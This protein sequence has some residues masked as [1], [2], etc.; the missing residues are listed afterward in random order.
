[1][2]YVHPIENSPEVDHAVAPIGLDKV[3][4]KSFPLK[5]PI[6][7]IKLPHKNKATVKMIDFFNFVI[8][9]Q[10]PNDSSKIQIIFILFAYPIGQI[11]A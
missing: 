5:N 1:M 10:P 9:V 3:I 6:K 8:T 7:T 4:A 11:R 2:A